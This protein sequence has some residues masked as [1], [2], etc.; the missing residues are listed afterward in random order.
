MILEKN[1]RMDGE[2][3]VVYDASRNI[4][5]FFRRYVNA[6]LPK[7]VKFQDVYSCVEDRSEPIHW[8]GQVNGE[9]SYLPSCLTQA[10]YLINC[11]DLKGHS[12]GGVTLCAKNHFGSV[13][14]S[15]KKASPLVAG[16]HEFVSPL[17]KSNYT[18][19]VDLESNPHIGRKTILY[20]IDGLVG[21]VS[22][23]STGAVG[24]EE[25]SWKQ[26]P[27]CGA[28]PSSIFLSQDPVAIDS[29][30]A[31]FLCTEPFMLEHNFVLRKFGVKVTEYLR[32]MAIADKPPSSVKYVFV[33]NSLG[34]H[35][36]WK[37]HVEKK[38]S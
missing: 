26:P 9:V 8:S 6:G 33:K 14:N 32:E 12:M 35:E 11:C 10:A 27:F 1:G 15:D 36:H 28:L 4:P 18:P 30:A 20:L 21:A 34:V 19:Y 13:I 16:L 2:D 31:D 23:R 25:C 29:V 3:I 17:I 38:Y 5:E 22:E 24:L 37:D 7:A